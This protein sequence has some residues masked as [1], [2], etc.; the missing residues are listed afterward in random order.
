MCPMPFTGMQYNPTESD[1]AIASV[2]ASTGE[3]QL[4]TFFWLKK[5]LIEA[6]KEQ[7]FLPLSS[8]IGMPK[9][10]GKTIKVFEYVPLL[11][12]RNINDQ[13][14]DADGAAIVKSYNVFIP[15]ASLVRSF[16]VEAD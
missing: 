12:D 16:V 13:G 7:Y 2:D 15:N 3:S 14:I 9:H 10:F 1:P 4:Q 6:R 8:T 5:S 11:D